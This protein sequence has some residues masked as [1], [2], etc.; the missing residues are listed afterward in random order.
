MLSFSLSLNAFPLT[1]ADDDDGINNKP[2]DRATDRQNA[3]EGGTEGR[4]G[5]MHFKAADSGGCVPFSW[6]VD[7]RRPLVLVSLLLCRIMLH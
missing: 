2:T 6:D 1:S 4:R 7:L 3:A 5:R